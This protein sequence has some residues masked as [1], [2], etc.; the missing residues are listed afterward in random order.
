M[1]SNVPAT[2]TRV[3]TGER[4]GFRFVPLR[5]AIA[6]PNRTAAPINT[7]TH[8]AIARTHPARPMMLARWRSVQPFSSSGRVGF[9]STT[10]SAL[11]EGHT[12][13]S[14]PIGFMH[15]G[16]RTARSPRVPQ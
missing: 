8:W 1:R 16:H 5:K 7:V 11:H 6:G 2:V 9:R 12:E 14:G 13:S 10:R 15:L 4:S 3:A